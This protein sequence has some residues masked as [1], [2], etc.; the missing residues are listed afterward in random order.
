MTRIPGKRSFL[1]FAY[2][3]F[4]VSGI[5]LETLKEFNKYDLNVTNTFL[6]P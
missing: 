4:S 1:M 5:E 6:S 2:Y 3:Y